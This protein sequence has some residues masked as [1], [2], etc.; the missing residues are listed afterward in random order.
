MPRTTFK[1]A[2]EPLAHLSLNTKGILVVA[3]PVC[4]LLVAMG[5][6]SQFERRTNAADAAVVHTYE[7]G[8]ELRQVLTLLVNAETGIRGYL[9]TQEEPFLV[10][11]TSAREEMPAHLDALQRLLSDRPAES[12]RLTTVRFLTNDMLQSMEQ[13]R[14]SAGRIPL[15]NDMAALERGRANMDE[16]RRELAAMTADEHRERESST[17][18]ARRARR[19][20]EIGIFAGG[21]LGLAGGFLAALLFTSRIT[22][23]VQRVEED[24]RRV[25]R[26]IPLQEYTSGTD[27][28]GRLEETL[29]ETSRL[30]TR[31]AEEL[32]AA[33]TDLESR[34]AQRTA[35][36]LEMNEELRKANEV[37]QAVVRSTPLA[38]WATDNEDK[39]TF[40]NPAAERIF[41][42]SEAEAIGQPLRVI[43]PELQEE[44]REW[45]E[46]FLKG[47]SLAAT[48]RSRIRKDSSRLEASIWTA[49]LRDA[50]G[51]VSGTIAMNDDITQRKLIEEQFRQSQKLEAVGQLAGGVA[52]DF[53]NLLTVIMGYVEMLIMETHEMP[54]LAEYLQEIQYAAERAASLT[55]QLLAFSR[56]QIIQS[57]ALDLNEVV[58]HSMRLLRRVIGED[59]EVSTH[60]DPNLG[61]V[62]ADPSHIDQVI[63][64]LVVN[65]RDAMSG[66]G[67]LTIDTAN[68]MLDEHYAGRHSGVKPGPYCLLAI[69]DT[70]GGM[71]AETR[72]R[73]FEPFFTT[74]ESGKGTG[75]GLSIVYGIVKQS[76]G[77][78]MVYSELGKG[79][80][81]KIYL[82]MIEAPAE[83]AAAESSGLDLRGT[84]TILVCED[85]TGI[86]RLVSH[87]L[88]RQG[89]RVLEAASPAEAVRIAGD[90]ERVDLLLTDV[91]MP[92]TNGFE[93]AAELRR[94]QPQCKVVYMSGYTDNRVSGSWNLDRGT[95]F[96]Q[97]PFTAANL[98]QKLREALGKAMAG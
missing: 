90:G 23:R 30:L 15:A 44:Y 53:N 96:L 83:A 18:E 89:Y 2:V 36:L 57:R 86:R 21:V 68:V 70:G 72:E 48:E 87:M 6:F 78:I 14:E 38:I 50:A 84:E 17:E 22:K 51:N 95:P 42:W 37:R 29:R 47:E 24:A 91:V 74:K 76:G 88:G 20:T 9:L 58:A 13:L 63:M 27:E 77:E 45:R 33:H 7:A 5:V 8:S 82:P 61:R 39:V 46:Q 41:G 56:R 11:Y 16:L 67:K 85:E 1:R 93:L 35:A 64:N 28:I 32:Q 12:A 59:I 4:A 34:V 49:P 55:S 3:I 98:R 92:E 60:L 25:A 65:A 79:T 40:W 26:G 80:C 71:T 52:H 43:P 62:R 97:K 31:Q 10:P 54:T 81:F 19:G 94:I 66:G 69:S 73:L 75:L